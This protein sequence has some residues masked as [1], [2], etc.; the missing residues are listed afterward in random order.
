ML[1]FLI[2]ISLTIKGLA[3][4]WNIQNGCLLQKINLSTFSLYFFLP[5][6]ATA[7]VDGPVDMFP[8]PQ[9]PSNF[10][11]SIENQGI[12]VYWTWGSNSGEPLPYY[13]SAKTQINQTNNLTYPEPLPCSDCNNDRMTHFE[14]EV[15]E[16]DGPFRQ[17]HTTLSSPN[18]DNKCTTHG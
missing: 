10:S 3:L 12:N 13:S 2:Y 16:N 4:I 9:T 8:A 7:I 15:S 6:A 11:Y 14:I 1:F 17:I 5:K 18:S